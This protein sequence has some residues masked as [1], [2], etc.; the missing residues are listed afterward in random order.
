[1][2]VENPKRDRVLCYE[3]KTVVKWVLYTVEREQKPWVV[4]TEEMYLMVLLN[5]PILIKEKFHM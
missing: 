2:Y 3:K 4:D 1:M 5:H